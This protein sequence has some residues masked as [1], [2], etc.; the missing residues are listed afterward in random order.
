MAQLDA[1]ASASGSGDHGFEETLRV[2]LFAVS[3]GNM[4][5]ALRIADTCTLPEVIDWY[6]RLREAHSGNPE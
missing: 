2:L 4:A 3:Q 5:D 1:I 6:G